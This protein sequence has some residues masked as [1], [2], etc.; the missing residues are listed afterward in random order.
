MKRFGILAGL[1][2]FLLFWCLIE[3]CGRPIVPSSPIV[4]TPTL[5]ATPVGCPIIATVNLTGNLSSTQAASTTGGILNLSPSGAPVIP[6]GYFYTLGSTFWNASKLQFISYGASGGSALQLVADPTQPVDSTNPQPNLTTPLLN[7]GLVGG[8]WPLT[9]A[10]PACS[11]VKTVTDAGGNSRQITF[12]FF[13]VH[14]L[15]TA[16][17]TINSA[18]LTQAIWAWYAFD[19]TGGAAVGTAS[20]LGG[21]GLGEGVTTLQCSIDRGYT[22]YMFFGDLLCFN[23]DGSLAT[24]GAM[25][26]PP[27]PS[28][29]VNHQAV[30]S[31]YLPSYNGSAISRVTVNFGTAGL[32]G[33]GKTNGL[34]GTTAASAVN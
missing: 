27:S 30:P 22:G 12:Q 28:G 5:T 8:G 10:T 3:S 33:Y 31:L 6:I 9:W 7:G 21:S 1:F 26:G 13:Q 15:G 25:Y 24:E 4:P 17:P 2:T 29:P 19:T 18:P 32:P 20:L 11:A 14:D 23:A 16:S 34:T